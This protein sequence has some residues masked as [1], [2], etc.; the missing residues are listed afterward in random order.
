M[1]PE[2]KRAALYARVNAE[3]K[4]QDTENQVQQLR[5]FANTQG[6][7]VVWEYVDHATGKHSDRL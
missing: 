6:W 2:G 5:Q 7:T 4:G 1:T 3:Y